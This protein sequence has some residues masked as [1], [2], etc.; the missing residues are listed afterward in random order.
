MMH[1]S[2]R[3]ELLLA[4]ISLLSCSLGY[5]P[6]AARRQHSTTSRLLN[7]ATRTSSVVKAAAAASSAEEDLELT[8]QIILNQMLSTAEERPDKIVEEDATDYM[9]DVPA[10]D[11]M[12]RAA[13]G[14]QVEKTPLWL[15]R[16]A[17]RHLPEYQAYKK[18]TDRNF[19]ELLAD[20]ISVAECTLQPIRRYP[21]DAA[22]LFS[23]ILVIPEA[24][25]IEVTMPGGVG[26]QVPNPLAGPE[27]VDTRLPSIEQLSSMKFVQDNLGH[28][29]TA[30]RQIRAQMESEEI[31]IPLIGFSAAPY[32]L[33]YYMIGGSS[34]KNTDRGIQWLEDYP[35][36]S[37]KLLNKLT[38]VVTEYLSAQV[39]AGCHMLQVFEAMGMM[40]DDKN[41][42]RYALPCLESI[43][44]EL[45]ARHPNVPLMVFCRGACEM[46]DKVA[47]LGLY[48]VITID[49]S[50][51][52][53]SV[54]QFVGDQVTLQG[55]YDPAELVEANGKTV[56]TV[57]ATAKQLL[58]E[59]GPQRLIANL[60]E[61]LGGKE[62]PDLVRAFVDAIHDESAS[63]IA[64]AAAAAED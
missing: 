15:F 20:P 33:L 8:R 3:A 44:T 37:H 28:V 14:E 26:I 59:L 12:I 61:G 40:I 49:G 17:G 1:S 24:M 29:L 51:D 47:A 9:T 35:E 64:A 54:R 5:L 42:E 4:V 39:E 27:E 34:K 13:M 10:N 55:N 57:Q 58:Q 6:P 19:L 36:E 38:R 16:Q 63:M 53:S 41:F 60:G 56:E 21:L 7:T 50:V 45:K 31:S 52:R 48:N 62:S 2:S 32:T 25:G 46:N 30:V 18:K 23:D 22:I 43:G 11:L